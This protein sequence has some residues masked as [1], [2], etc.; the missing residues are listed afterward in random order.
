M[1]RKLFKHEMHATARMY[2]PLFGML[3]VMTALSKLLGMFTSPGTTSAYEA[4]LMFVYSMSV[5]AVPVAIV[6]ITIQRFYK[7]LLCDEGYLMFTLP[8]RSEQLI[9]SKL[10]ASVIWCA[11]G[12]LFAALSIMIAVFDAEAWSELFRGIEVVAEYLRLNADINLW[13]FAAEAA[14][15]A[16]IS[17]CTSSLMVYC[18]MALGQL[19]HKNK[20]LASFGMYLALNIALQVVTTVVVSFFVKL[21]TDYSI[22]DPLL[23]GM[24]EIVVV[25]SVMG[26]AIVFGLVCA[27]GFFFATNG[28]LKK[29]LN[30]E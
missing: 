25:H 16:L 20:L 18:A 14:V 28:L 1:L 8:V 30:L 23:D 5:A 15:A 17:L 6:I 22:F 11:A 7:N 9:L 4:I 26:I 12:A 29:K 2:L 3:A 27:A 24:T 13:L 21:Q 19:F 10:F